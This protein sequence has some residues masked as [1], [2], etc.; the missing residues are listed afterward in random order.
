MVRGGLF[1]AELLQTGQAAVGELLQLLDIL[2]RQVTELL[3]AGDKLLDGLG[4]LHVHGHLEHA[5]FHLVQG[6]E[7][8]LHRQAGHLDALIGLAA[9]AGDAGIVHMQVHKSGSS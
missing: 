9:P 6:G 1:A 3:E 4:V 8:G 7:V 2:L 5:V